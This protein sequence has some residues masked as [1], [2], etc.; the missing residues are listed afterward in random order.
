MF[1]QKDDVGLELVEIM[2]QTQTFQVITQY[3]FLLR[4]I[5]KIIHLNWS[6]FLYDI[7]KCSAVFISLS[8][9]QSDPSHDIIV[10]YS[11]LMSLIVYKCLIVNVAGDELL[12]TNARLFQWTA[13]K[14]WSNTLR[15]KI[16]VQEPTGHTFNCTYQINELHSMRKSA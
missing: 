7:V 8:L 6:W 1:V 11:I 3:L 13:L 5:I 9:F 4:C 2:C 12:V 15:A 10:I 14:H 16:F